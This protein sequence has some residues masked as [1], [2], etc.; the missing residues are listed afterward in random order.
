V[1]RDEPL[2]AV[3]V[4]I[5]IYSIHI[6]W[7]LRPL[8]VIRY[9]DAVKKI[10]KLQRLI[11]LLVT[12]GFRDPQGCEAPGDGGGATAVRGPGETVER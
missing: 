12:P 4:F 1:G 11:K 2:K 8:R 10:Y 3:S 9:A 5:I 6:H 7:C